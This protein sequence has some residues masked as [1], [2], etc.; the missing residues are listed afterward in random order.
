LLPFLGPV[1]TSMK[2]SRTSGA[3]LSSVYPSALLS[4]FPKLLRLLM[5]SRSE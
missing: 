3:I 5:S 2:P 1:A 4:G